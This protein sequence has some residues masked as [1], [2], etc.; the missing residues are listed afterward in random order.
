MAD[1]KVLGILFGVG[2][3]AMWAIEA[4]LGKL[5]FSS[6][7]FIQVTASEV[8]FAALT[9]FVYIIARREHVRFSRRNLGNF[10]VV[11]L[12]GT[13]FAPL[14]F[15]LGLTQTLAVNATLI[16]H[17]QPL[18]VAVFGLFLLEEKLRKQD[19]VAGLLTVFAVVL[20]TGRT[21]DNLANL[22]LGNSGDLVV[23]L[24]T[25]G[26]AIVAIPGKRL[27]KEVSS[28]VIVGYRFLIA[29]MVFIPVLLY[30]NQL[31][32]NSIHQVLLGIVV[33]LGYIFYYEGLRRVKASQVALCE[34]SSPFFAAILAWSFL[35]EETTLMQIAG[36]ILLIMGL[37]IL[38]QEKSIANKMQK[39]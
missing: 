3:G 9:A 27:T 12:V 2:A 21:V 36:A 7:T 23:L 30:S 8:F 29:S 35:G 14:M 25:L 17:L 1:Q 34:L 24:A 39:G 37:Y 10:L 38:T 32:I 31:V 33:G 26:W 20:I 19:V 18:F 4:I 22:R 13:V 6:F 5:L 28:V 11:G 16:A 15:F